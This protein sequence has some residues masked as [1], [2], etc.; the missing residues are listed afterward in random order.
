MLD[1]SAV[2]STVRQYAD[3]VR[4]ALAP[5]AIVLYGSYASGTA[6]EGSD[7]DVAVIFDGYQGDWLSDSALLWKLACKRS[8]DIEPV[9][10][11]RAHDRSGFAAEVMQTG[12]LI[13]QSSKGTEDGAKT[14]N[15][16]SY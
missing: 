3:D 8:L 11:D 1:Q 16:V 12:H 6:R 5:A 2:I 13:Y 14:A 4:Q 15:P 9:L 10:L 7:I